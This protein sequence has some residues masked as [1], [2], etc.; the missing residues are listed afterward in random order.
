MIYEISLKIRIR[1]EERER[2]YFE[3]WRIKGKCFLPYER[4]ILEQVFL[5]EWPLGT[6]PPD[7]STIFMVLVKADNSSTKEMNRV[8]TRGRNCIRNYLAKQE[9]PTFLVMD[10]KE[11]E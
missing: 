4:P 11:A 6:P 2:S 8:F 7:P 9:V 5:Y 10:Q 1:K 3:A